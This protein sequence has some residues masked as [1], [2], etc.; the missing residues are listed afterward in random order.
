MQSDTAMHA[1]LQQRLQYRPAGG[2]DVILHLDRK[3]HDDGVPQILKWLNHQC[4]FNK[5]EAAFDTFA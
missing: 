3:H 2:S 5:N 1:E 4:K